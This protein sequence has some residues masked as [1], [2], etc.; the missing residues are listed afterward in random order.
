MLD[1]T[2]TYQVDL[3]FRDPDGD[4]LTYTAET[5]DAATVEA[6]VFAGG[7]TIRGVGTGDARVDV[8]ATDPG[9][10]SAG[11]GFS[12]AVFPRRLTDH[13]AGD[14]D[15]SWS[16]DG[17]R[18]AFMSDRDGNR[19][20][21][22]VNAD[23][24]DVR[25]LTNDS[26]SDYHPSWSPDGRR[27]AFVS[28]RDGNNE[29]YAMDADGTG[30]TRLTTHFGD[31]YAPT[32]S[33][34]GRRIAF[35]TRNRSDLNTVQN[36]LDIFVMNADGTG[37]SRLTRHPA[38]DYDPSWSSDGRGIAFVSTRDGNREIYSV[39]AD[40][41]DIRNLTNDAASDYDPSWSSDGRR[42]AF[43]ST[44]GRHGQHEIHIMEADGTVT[45]LSDGGL[46][47]IWRELRPAWSPDGR[48]ITFDSYE[49][50]NNDIYITSVPG[51]R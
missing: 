5:S 36:G 37:L 3:A 11:R 34:D 40:G 38:D 21:Y 9:G 13:S 29:I 16:P 15:P 2:I 44:R 28:T 19:E 17:R 7:V 24:T 30:V 14:Y 20:I 41:T 42:I 6:S 39:N 48:R 31:D 12:Q 50:A 35:A 4:V 33:P 47:L 10:L 27:I 32:W 45:F 23:G 51:S 43:T 26:A 22:S 18:I 46:Q 1:E 49:A 8:R 25:N